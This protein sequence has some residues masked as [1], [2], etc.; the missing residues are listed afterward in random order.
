MTRADKAAT[1]F[2]PR[3]AFDASEDGSLSYGIELGT[4]QSTRASSPERGRR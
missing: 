4:V 1:T 3:H 2:S